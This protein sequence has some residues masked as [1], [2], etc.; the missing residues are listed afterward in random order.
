MGGS[1]VGEVQGGEGRLL[2]EKESWAD[3]PVGNKGM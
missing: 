3:G 1:G 2:Q